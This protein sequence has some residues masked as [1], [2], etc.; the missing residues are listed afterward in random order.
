MD[1]SIQ[2]YPFTR[3]I[4][5]QPHWHVRTDKN[6]YFHSTILRLQQE[7]IGSGETVSPTR[8]FFHYTKELK[9]LIS[10]KTAYLITLLDNN[11]KTAVYIGQNIHELYCYLEMIISQTK[12]TTSGQRSHHFGTSSST[13]NDESSLQ[14]VVEAIYMRQKSI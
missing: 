11:I 1:N 7:I 8:L 9:A 6:E 14:S 2:T 10:T 3:P 4:L 5:T 13:N 12:L